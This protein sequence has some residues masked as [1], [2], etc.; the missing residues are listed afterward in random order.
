VKFKDD[1]FSYER[2]ERINWIK[3]TLESPNSDLRCG[4]ISKKRKIDCSRRVAILN[5][6]YVVVIRINTTKNNILK[7]NFITAYIADKNINKILKMPK[8]KPQK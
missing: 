6:N 3:E 4:W 7:A 2:A 5:K 1:T 8:W